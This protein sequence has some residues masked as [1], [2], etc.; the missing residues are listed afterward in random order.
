MEQ[1][2]ESLKFARFVYQY[3]SAYSKHYKSKR[4]VADTIEKCLCLPNQFKQSTT[5]PIEYSIANCDRM[6][7]PYSSSKTASIWIDSMAFPSAES[8][9]ICAL[10]HCGNQ[11][12][13]SKLI[14]SCDR[15]WSL[16]YRKKPARTQGYT[17]D[18]HFR[19]PLIH[20]LTHVHI[21]HT[22]IQLCR[23]SS[24]VHTGA[25]T[26]GSRVVL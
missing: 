5:Y 1:S 12:F 2:T 23:T 13:H 24:S 6:L 15:R 16:S 11:L 18:Q 21:Q 9:M 19:W 7:A 20:L 8:L 10:R 25:Q 26:A 14:E 22:L 4:N 3:I 17:R